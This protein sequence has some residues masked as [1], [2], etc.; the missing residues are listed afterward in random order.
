MTSGIEDSLRLMQTGAVPEAVAIAEALA[1]DPESRPD[2]L[3]LLSMAAAHDGD[4]DKALSLLGQAVAEDPD[5]V[6]RRFNYAAMALD[7]G[8][9]DIAV[10]EFSTVAESVPQDPAAH[11]LLGNAL[12]KAGRFEEAVSAQEKAVSLAPTHPGLWA[13]LAHAYLAWGKLE[14]ADAGNE[15]A[16]TLG[17][18][19]PELHFNVAST[20][21][22]KGDLEAAVRSFQTTIELDPRH[23]RA[24]TSLGVVMRT[25][26][27]LEAGLASQE[28]AMTLYPESID[29][30]WN[31]AL[32]YL[33]HGRY[34]EGWPLYEARRER[35]PQ[36]GRE[37]FGIPWDGRPQFDETLVI[38]REQGLG[39]TIMN[40]RFLRRAK[41]R[42]GRL[43]LRCQSVLCPLLEESLDAPGVIIAPFELEPYP[44]LYAPMMSLPYLLGQGRDLLTDQ[45]PYLTASPT[46]VA[47]WAQRLGPKSRPR[48][49]LVWQGNPGFKADSKRSI[50]IEAF[51]PLLE[52]PDIEVISLQQRHGLEQLDAL[53]VHLR[54]RELEGPV[55]QDG[56][57]LDTAAVMMNL[58]FVVTSDTAPAHLSGAMGVPTALVL[59]HHPD[60]RWGQ[61]PEA[62]YATVKGFNQVTSGEWKSP[63][64]AAAAFVKDQ[65]G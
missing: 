63:V 23:A 11:T 10:E 15:H 48:I 4:A 46:R 64:E 57:F 24:H 35:D 31:L 25:L 58:D 34:E 21:V 12:T 65:L 19:E 5:N 59:G 50:P 42:V 41:E 53:P 28:H 30:R 51:R 16:L 9:T 52:Q 38:E 61:G 1:S 2:A 17:P 18:K 29:V 43:I 22:L 56:A 32:S 60:W 54:P 40:A 3:Q 26:G 47:E 27:H 36:L 33:F 8:S 45:G 49:G 39:D 7:L 62:W 37:G 6:E 44:G 20:K 13:N 55:D 14:A